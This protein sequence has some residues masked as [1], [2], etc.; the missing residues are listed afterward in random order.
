[1]MDLG[2]RAQSAQRV[3]RQCRLFRSLHGV[4]SPA[5]VTTVQ[6]GPPVCV[7]VLKVSF[8]RRRWQTWL[9]AGQKGHKTGSGGLVSKTSTNPQDQRAGGRKGGVGGVRHVGDREWQTFRRR[10]FPTRPPRWLSTLCAQ[11]PSL[12]SRTAL[13]GIGRNPGETTCRSLEDSM[14]GQSGHG[15][16]QLHAG[17]IPPVPGEW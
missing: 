17:T 2:E 5:T 7:Q 12:H 6:I 13:S 16:W 1:M 4:G 15:R 11:A 14:C 10:I 3:A 8:H 9:E